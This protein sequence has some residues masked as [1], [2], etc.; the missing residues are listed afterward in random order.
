M[1]PLSVAIDGPAACGKSSL[2][3]ALA[4]QIG[5]SHLETGGLYR[6]VAL[7]FLES[8]GPTDDPKR[9][10]ELLPRMNLSIRSDESTGNDIHFFLGNR[11]VT[12]DIRSEAVGQWAS[13]VATIP[14]VR[15]Y[16]LPLQRQFAKNGRVVMDGR[17]IGTVILPEAS[18]KIFLSAPAQTRAWRRWLQ[19]GGEMSP[20]SLKEIQDDLE[21]RD[22]QDLTRNI[23]PLSKAPDALDLDNSHMTISESVEWIL[24]RLP[25]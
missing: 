4:D 17:D 13:T 19:L 7:S 23:A 20:R 10:I 11:D 16:L 8:G 5:L 6:S 18:L 22:R 2:A 25:K 1:T 21:E 14:E 9:I 3:K 15:A 24:E 12:T